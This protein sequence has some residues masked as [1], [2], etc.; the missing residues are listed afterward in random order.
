MSSPFPI[1]PFTQIPNNL[2]DDLCKELSGS[3]F[4]VISI[5][6][7]KTYGWHKTSDCISIGQLQDVT[8]L[9]RNGV[10]KAI[11]ELEGLGLILKTQSNI[12]GVSLPN[13]YCLNV[14]KPIDTIYTENAPVEGVVQNLDGGGSAKNALGVVQ[15]MHY[16][17]VQKMHPQKK[18]STKEI[19]T[20]ENHHLPSSKK[21]STP[22]VSRLPF[23]KD[24]DFS[25]KI[26]KKTKGRE[27]ELKSILERWKAEERSPKAI[28]ATLKAYKDQPLGKIGSI[29]SWMEKVYL[30]KFESA[31]ADE[32]FE[33]RRKFAEKMENNNRNN[34]YFAKDKDILS[35]TCGSNE[36]LYDI[37]GTKKGSEEFWEK[38]KLGKVGFVQWKQE[39]RG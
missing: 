21:S 19:L 26:K 17:V 34:Y 12:D 38:H 25:S 10:I 33:I 36:T 6:C 39:Q 1:C 30:Q 20:K 23:G 2:F 15:K 16:G 13:N 9:S 27:E 14:Q 24:D 18:D 8:G 31:D 35:Y 11:K 29:S 5:M 37:R 28:E 4:K 7:R 32:L 22:K 3:A